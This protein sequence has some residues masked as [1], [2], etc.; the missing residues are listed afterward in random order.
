MRKESTKRKMFKRNMLFIIVGLAILLAIFIS[1][2][3]FIQDLSVDKTTTGTSPGDVV[4]PENIVMF[5]AVKEGDLIRF[6]FGFNDMIGYN[7]NVKLEIAD[8]VNKSVYNS[9]FNV[10][11]T[12]FVDYQFTL[13]GQP[14]GKAYE[15]EI[16]LNSIQ[17]G[18]SNSGTAY[19]TFS[20]NDK[21]YTVERS[22]IPIPSYTP[23]EIIQL[24]ENRYLQ[25]AKNA[26]QTLTKGSFN[27]TLVRLGYFIHLQHETYG[28]EVTDFRADIKVR[29][30]GNESERLSSS[31]TALIVGSKQY[32]YSSGSEFDGYKLL[33][34]G[35]V[36]E[37]YILFEG[38]PIGLTDKVE[39]IVGSSYGYDSST[40][41]WTNL[42]YS[43]DIEL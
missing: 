33:D 14:T 35:I 32:G 17:K 15:W 25:S 10:K 42:L 7:G 38:V 11:S 19:L 9:N 26:G 41:T 40:L 8:N 29:N 27:V 2:T 31:D 3:N 22:F 1:Q 30:I 20:I 39:V 13:Y 18:M 37:G 23:N 28:G 12:D 34:S 4:Y 43:F 24:Y 21:K 5:E 6:Y 16:S 36:K